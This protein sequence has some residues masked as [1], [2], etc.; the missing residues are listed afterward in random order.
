M[1]VRAFSA[2]DAAFASQLAD[3]EGWGG[4]ALDYRDLVKLEPRGC[5]VAEEG[6]QPVGMIASI[7]YGKLGWIGA[8][9]VKTGYRRRGYGQ[10]LVDRAVGWL[11]DRGARTIGLDATLQAVPFYTRAG[12][13]PAYESLHLRRKAQAAPLPIEDSLVPMESTDLHAVTMFDWAPFGGRRRRVL[14]A[15][16][17]CSPV[18]YLAQDK[19][20]VGGYLMA[21]P[22]RDCWII[23]PWVCLRSAES[24]LTRALAAIG[25]EPAR[26]VVP[27]VN[28]HALELVRAHGFKVYYRELRMYQGDQ[29]G[30]GR[31][32]QVYAIA[33]P[34][35]G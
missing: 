18:A 29:E 34:E 4:S 25:Q 19:D 14:R 8:L 11:L 23:G 16:L 13:R 15:L 9:V 22:G 7:A 26:V 33:S 21:R 2:S 5:F 20:G 10:A 24:L 31:P 3:L 6:G 17:Q 28:E 32:H 30:I 27:K 12:F 35:K 1:P